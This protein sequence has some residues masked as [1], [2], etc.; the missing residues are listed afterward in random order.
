M[1]IIDGETLRLEGVIASLVAKAEVDD[2]M[3]AGHVA[4]IEG[5]QLKVNK[6]EAEIDFL[7][8][9]LNAMKD[10]KDAMRDREAKIEAERD[11]AIADAKRYQWIRTCENDSLIIYGD[12]SHCEL[13]MEEALDAA[14]DKAME[15]EHD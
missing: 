15:A 3:L 12:T 7:A 9:E 13:M 8:G 11:A 6:Q 10:W 1:S 4:L 5:W 2:A 14:I